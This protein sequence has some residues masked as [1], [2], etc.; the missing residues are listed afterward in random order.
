MV[1]VQFDIV[2][3]YLDWFGLVWRS[4]CKKKE[5]VGFSKEMLSKFCQDRCS[6][7]GYI[8]SYNNP[9]EVILIIK[10]P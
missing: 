7:F 10:E 3:H 4:V 6:C 9:N 1:L 2:L 8:L 5:N